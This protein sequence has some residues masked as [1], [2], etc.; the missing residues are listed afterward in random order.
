MAKRSEF[1]DHV[2]ELMNGLGNVLP[3]PMFGA[4]GLFYEGLCFAI[5]AEDTLY[6]KGDG[7]NAARFDAAQMTPF[8]YE[9]KMG[10]RI[11]TSYRQ[12]PADALDNAVNMAQ[13]AR[14]G[15][16]AAL[17]TAHGRAPGKPRR[18]SEV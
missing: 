4:W 10:E 15:Y 5:V 2:V 17:R 13:W 14:E 7:V 8:I 16:E 1:V 3:K 18:H 11:V 9:S 6:L 12:A